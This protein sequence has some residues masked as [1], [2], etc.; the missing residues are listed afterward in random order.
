MT[1]SSRETG[2]RTW[3]QHAL[4]FVAG[5][6]AFGSGVRLTRGSPLHAAG[7]PSLTFYA[8]TRPF[9]APPG[10]ALAPGALAA[11]GELLESPAGQTIGSFVTNCFCLPGGAMHA[12]PGLEFQALELRDGTLYAMCSGLSAAGGAKTSAIVGGTGRFAGARGT[13]LHRAAATQSGRHDVIEIVVTL[14]V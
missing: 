3:L 4:A 6:V 1:D 10:S 14:A 9:V 7:D 5:G 13:C 2:R 12:H 8:R 11:S